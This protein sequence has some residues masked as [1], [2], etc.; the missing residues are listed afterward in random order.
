MSITSN[1]YNEDEFIEQEN[2]AEYLHEHE[3]NENVIIEHENNENVIINTEYH[4]E[5]NVL[6][7]ID[8][9]KDE[10]E[11]QKWYE[12]KVDNENVVIDSDYENEC[13]A[14]YL[15]Y[16]NNADEDDLELENTI[17]VLNEIDEQNGSDLCWRFLAN[18]VWG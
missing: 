10:D 9:D 5:E 17:N 14:T 4:E 8:P 13:D 15:D 16:E 7:N 12:N 18:S 11:W 3:N 6:E 1:E 2:E